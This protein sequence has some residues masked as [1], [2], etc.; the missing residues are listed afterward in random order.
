MLHCATIKK[1]SIA[2]AGWLSWLQHCF[3]HQKAVGL[4]PTEGTYL[5]FRFN[6]WLG[7]IWEANWSMLLFHTDLFLSLSNQ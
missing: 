7:H 6:F 1:E 2:F 3:V 4:I 5:G